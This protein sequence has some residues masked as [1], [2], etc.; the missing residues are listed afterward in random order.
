[1]S[2]ERLKLTDN[3][4]E[5]M[6][7][8]SEGNPGACTALSELL[9]N[10]EV[11]PDCAFGG[12]GSIMSL[13]TFGIYGSDIYILWNDICG[14]NIVGMI[15]VLRATQLGELRVDVLK[16]ACSRQDRSG[17]GMIDVDAIY[18]YVKNRLPDFDKESLY[19]K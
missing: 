12:V 2:H 13:D 6:M 11:D 10:G 4:S 8:M 16:D 18:A 9:L 3:G 15:A 5:M 19:T 7:K 1:M 17:K 14:K